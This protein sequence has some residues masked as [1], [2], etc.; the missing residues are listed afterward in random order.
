MCLFLSFTCYLIILTLIFLRTFITLTTGFINLRVWSTGTLT[1]ISLWFSTCAFYERQEIC[2]PEF[3]ILLCA[4][5]QRKKLKLKCMVWP[6]TE[7][8][9]YLANNNRYQNCV[10][11]VNLPKIHCQECQEIQLS[12]THLTIQIIFCS[13]SWSL[14]FTILKLLSASVTDNF[15]IPFR[16]TLLINTTNSTLMFQ[17]L[18]KMT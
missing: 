12:G 17:K 11:T 3:E 16:T 4:W 10:K 14:L 9:C 6:S 8:S 2:S 5:K 1:Y 7:I 18:Q 13:L 15:I